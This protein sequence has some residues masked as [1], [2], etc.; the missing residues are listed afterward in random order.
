[1]YNRQKWPNLILECFN[2][3]ISKEPTIFCI[4]SYL[5][6]TNASF[7]KTQKLKSLTIYT[8]ISCT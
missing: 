1:M 2:Q 3:P 7:H 4:V 8:G 6:N 5:F